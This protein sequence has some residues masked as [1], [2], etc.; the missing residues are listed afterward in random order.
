MY[1]GNKIALLGGTSI[2]G[3]Y[4]TKQL[5]TSGYKIKIL[6]Q[7]EC[8]FNIYSDQI[9]IVKGNPADYLSLLKLI[10]NCSVVINSTEIENSYN[11]LCSIVAKNAIKAGKIFEVDRYINVSDFSIDIPGDKKSLKTKTLSQIKRLVYPRFIKD[12]QSEYELIRKSDLSWTIVRCPA[13]SPKYESPGIKISTEDCPG[14]SIHPNTIAKFVVSLIN[15]KN[16]VHKA[17]FVSN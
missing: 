2:I 13:V 1:S 5:L 9:E 7:D 6:L 3:T 12:R 10:E 4:I 16:Y 17:P 14:R 8:D 15:D 11:S